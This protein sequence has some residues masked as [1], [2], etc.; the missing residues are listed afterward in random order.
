MTTLQTDN[1]TPVSVPS[2]QS[3]AIIDVFG[4]SGKKTITL[5]SH[6]SLTYLVVCSGGD[7]DIH[8]VTD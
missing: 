2:G 5:S 3:L 8:I 6:S 1:F 4:G 7:I